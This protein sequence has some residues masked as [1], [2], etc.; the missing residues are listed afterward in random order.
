[1]RPSYVLGGRAMQIIRGD[2]CCDYLLGTLPELVPSEVKQRYPN[3]K[4]GQINTVLGK[5]PLLFDRYL[6]DADRG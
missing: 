3:D 1:V 4:T 2:R 6:S 5:N